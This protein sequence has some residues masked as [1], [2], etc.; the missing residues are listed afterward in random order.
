MNVLKIYRRYKA[1]V[2]RAC[3]RQLAMTTALQ[4]QLAEH[5]QIGHQL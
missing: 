5:K 2:S 4:K 1:R 3:A